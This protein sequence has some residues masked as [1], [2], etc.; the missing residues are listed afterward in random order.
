MK[1][2]DQSALSK[3]SYRKRRSYICLCLCI[4]LCAGILF[5]CA[6]PKDPSVDAPSEG[7]SADYRG[8][9]GDAAQL[10][11][12]VE[13]MR[14]G[15]LTDQLGYG[16]DRRKIVLFRGSEAGTSFEVIDLSTDT[17]VYSGRLESAGTDIQTGEP[18]SYGDFSGLV[19]NGEY[20]IRTPELGESYSFY[21]GD[22]LYEEVFRKSILAYEALWSTQETYAAGMLTTDAETICTLLIAYEYYT[23][24]FTDDLGGMDS[25]NNIPDLMD[26]IRG[27]VERVMTLSPDRL[28]YEQLS[29]YV[30]ILSQ[31]AQDYRNIDADYAGAC[32]VAAQEGWR[33]LEQKDRTGADGSYY[34]YAAS[35][36]YRAS[37]LAACH[38]ALRNY[39]NAAQESGGVM[40][41]YG[42]V[43][44]L[45]CKNTVDVQL[46]SSIIT[47][48]MGEVER[49]SAQSASNPYLVCSY[50]MPEIFTNM[51]RL[52]VVNYV[53]TNHE[54]ETVQEN[55][56]HYLLGR[57][58]TGVCYIE[59]IER[60]EKMAAQTVTQDS[61]Q[62]ASLI[63]LMCEIIH[64]ENAD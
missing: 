62:N 3:K 64:S 7:D 19:E 55:H 51:S 1:A 25:G 53:I 31:F 61:L 54:Y 60:T 58:E 35:E 45:S 32:L 24:L 57:N 37:G 49:V 6:G 23:G 20:R 38:T 44:Y 59:G 2:G 48:L 56:L 9:A 26:L 36:L 63:L 33:L 41:F 27:R 21:I 22:G 29:C 40:D 43:G 8:M 39:L 50:D 52:A 4:Q 30:G 17:A 15:V 46:C 13:S 34:F 18:V 47:A 12:T 28:N 5:G 16:T 14:P 11:Y 42:K 10:Q